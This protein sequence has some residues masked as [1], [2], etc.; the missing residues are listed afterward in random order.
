MDD[1]VSPQLVERGLA[2]LAQFVSTLRL[3]LSMEKRAQESLEQA[4]EAAGFEFQR[5]AILSK[6]DIPDFMV[7]VD[8]AEIALELKTR[9]QR[10]AIYRQLERYA[11]HERVC[12]VLLMTGTAMGLPS[13]INGKPARVASLGAGWL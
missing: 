12:G 2:R 9:A 10:K 6:R 4:L 3:D 5:E 8:G 13:L 11:E 1:V 7:K